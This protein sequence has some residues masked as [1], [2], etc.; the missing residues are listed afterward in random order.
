MT[1]VTRLS[2]DKL[3]LET[4]FTMEYLT[5][6]L[7]ENDTSPESA[8]ALN[9]NL[10][11]T[12]D[13]KANPLAIDIAIS[14]KRKSGTADPNSNVP[15]LYMNEDFL[16]III[17]ADSSKTCFLKPDLSMDSARWERE[18]YVE[19]INPF[20]QGGSTGDWGI[21]ILTV[22]ACS[23][24]HSF[25]KAQ[26]ITYTFNPEIGVDFERLAQQI[27]AGA[28]TH[29]LLGAEYVINAEP[30]ASFTSANIPKQYATVDALVAFMI[31]SV[32]S[33][34]ISRGLV[35][36]LTQTA[37]RLCRSNAATLGWWE[38]SIAA[39]KALYK[40]SEPMMEI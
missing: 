12:I 26:E 22:R 29:K 1:V 33:E 21:M 20:R 4:V 13:N 32:V 9:I 16:T 25:T 2:D 7:Y 36:E 23:A 30:E 37:E 10:S 31:E 17:G 39:T 34:A 35:S 38:S 24:P 5:P 28:T 3:V 8:L 6:N 11:I 27:P 40:Q 15:V 14:A 18:Y 19:A